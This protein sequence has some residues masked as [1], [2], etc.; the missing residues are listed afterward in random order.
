MDKF[1][2]KAFHR[3]TY[4]LYLLGAKSKAG[5]ANACIINTFI[6]LASDPMVVSIAVNKTGYT[7]EI[8]AET[9]MFSISSITE[10]APFEIFKAY[11]LRSGRDGGKFEAL[12][13]AEYDSAGLPYLAEHAN[14]RFLCKVKSRADYGSHTLYVAEVIEAEVLSSEPSVT[15]SYY[16]TNIKPKPEKTPDQKSGWRC[17]VCGY[18]HEGEELPEGFVCPLCGHGV[19]DFEKI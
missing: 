16:Q 12:A 14:A 6:Q 15:Y 1:D 9:G 13:E 3:V 5:M 8:I 2:S 7:H 4:G 10:S 19:V 11:G 17:T 18:V